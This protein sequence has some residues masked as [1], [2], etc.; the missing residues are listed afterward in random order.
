M[1]RKRR[2]R[3]TWFPILGTQGSGEGGDIRTTNAISFAVDAPADGNP[4]MAITPITYDY[5][6]EAPDLS[7]T[8]DTLTEIVGNEYIC[9]RILGS[10]F[11]EYDS[12]YNAQNNTGGP[13]AVLTTVGIFVARAASGAAAPFQSDIP[14]GFAQGTL[15]DDVN[16]Y[17][18]QNPATIRE[19][20][21]WRKSWILSNQRKWRAR[22]EDTSDNVRTVQHLTFPPNNIYGTF[23]GG[24]AV[25]VKTRRR[26]GNDDRLFVVAD[27]RSYPFGTTSSFPGT[28]Y[29]VLDVR[30]FAQL[31]RAK[32]R[33]N[34]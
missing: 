12:P 22:V 9:K 26:V 13:D 7:P 1:R 15:L 10:C 2:S 24:E 31:V 5:P 32:N 11:A 19:P 14:V 27:V 16:T 25:D 28:V 4:S 30:M 17:S 29:F 23:R 34:F 33:G 21:M 3:G 8:A 6:Q 20:W 18:P